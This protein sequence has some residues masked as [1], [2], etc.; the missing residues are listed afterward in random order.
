MKQLRIHGPG[1]IAVDDLSAPV[2]GPADVTVRVAACGI[3]GS[4]LGY[5]ALGGVGGP[6]GR[7]TP[8]GHELSGVVEAVGG[9]V[10]GITP[11]LRVVVNPMAAGNLIGNGGP[12]GGLTPLLLVRNAALGDAI[13]PIPD[14]LPADVAALAEP[15][16]VALHA[17]SRAQVGPEAT[18]AVFGAGPIGLGVVAGLAA[19]GVRDVVAID[20]SARRLEV[21]R[22]LGASAAVDPARERVADV[23]GARHGWATLFG[24]PV[25]GTDVF[26]EATGA[27]SVVQDVVAMS[28]FGARL[29]VV[30]VHKQPVAI[31]L[32]RLLSSELTI[33]GAIGY[34]TEF[35]E[36]VAL[37][38]ARGPELASLVS[39]RFAFERAGDAFVAAA[40]PA[41]ALK[42]VVT[43]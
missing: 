3:C 15:L 19:R 7:P 33:T 14:H 9:D 39:H 26:I 34:P 5:V 18:V 21:A 38:A 37:L 20:Y 28:R 11:G 23:L 43:F 27:P 1:R 2:P 6:S 31:D 24:R 40:D 36:A 25:V 41:A 35:P 8:L 16:A 10:A 42:V 4:D 32:V 17:V 22:A 30:A 12:E 29:V 13:H